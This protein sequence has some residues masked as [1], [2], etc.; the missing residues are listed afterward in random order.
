MNRHP[1]LEESAKNTLSERSSLSTSKIDYLI[2][3]GLGSDQSKIT[4]YRKV[5][6][7]PWDGVQNQVLRHY[8]AEV[9]ENLL[10]I[11]FNDTTVWNRVKTL[12]LRKQPGRISS[13]REEVSDEGL[14]SLL[15]K[16]SDY[17]LPLDTIFEVYSRGAA[18]GGEKAGF[19]RLNSFIAGGRARVLDA[20]LVEG[21]APKP[22]KT[23][24]RTLSIVKRV[25]AEKKE[26]N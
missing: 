12:L 24:D 11:V 18:Q 21:Y 23:N 14:R 17:E 13:L 5:I 10:D 22:E 7:S 19:D 15:K 4:Y 16:S 9:L 1:A 3:S 2:R 25:L 26:K 8:T 6:A 20:D